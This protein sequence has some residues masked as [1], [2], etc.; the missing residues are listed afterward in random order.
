MYRKSWHE[1]IYDAMQEPNGKK[2]WFSNMELRKRIAARENIPIK[3]IDKS[4]TAYTAILR[5]KGCVER[6]LKPK[7]MQYKQINQKEYIYRLTDKP[8]NCSPR[9][10]KLAIARKGQVT[11]EQ[12][13]LGFD[14]WV[15]YKYLPKWY[16]NLMK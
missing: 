13:D 1:R 9:G 14:L 11:Q 3:S 2:L 6:A 5:R 7:A 12:I 15:K 8:L 10:E 16:R 4:L